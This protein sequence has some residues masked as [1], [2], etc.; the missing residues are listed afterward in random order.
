MNIALIYP[1]AATAH[2]KLDK[3]SAKGMPIGIA[4]LGAYLEKEGH[5][6]NLVDAEA[7]D[8]SIE[9]TIKEALKNNPK[10]VGISC[11][12]VSIME[13]YKLVKKI[14]EENPEIKT[15]IGGSHASSTPKK[16]LSSS[17]YLDFVIYGEGEI[18]L[19]E[20][21][22][23]IEE[24][25]SFED[26]NGL[27]YKKNNEIIINKPRKLIENLDSIPF[28]ARHLLPLNKYIHSI[29]WE[30]TTIMITS[31][32]CPN[33]CIFCGSKM[34][35]GRRAR[36]RSVKNVIKEID[37][38]VNK[39]KIKNI[40]MNDD[41]FTLNKQRTIKICKEIIKNNFD[42]KFLCAS[43]VNTMDQEV[44]DYLEK[45]G[46]KIVTF[47]IESGDEQILKNIKKGIDL[48]QVKKAVE[49]VKNT[50]MEAHGSFMFGNPGETEETMKKTIEFAKS[51]PLDK[52]QF[53]ITTPFPGTELWDIAKKEGGIKTEDFSQ[54]YFYNC[55]S[56][57]PT[58]LT[59]KKIKEYQKKAYNEC[60][61]STKSGIK[62]R[63]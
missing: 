21:V 36:F 29:F 31:R 61:D 13:A 53:S 28:P 42:I 62:M 52:Y 17:E 57:V 56:Y 48:N 26:I 1:Y 34:T 20:L 18:T 15:M 9:D 27:V 10:L 58:G 22:K 25:K 6:M 24:N 19:L 23:A 43:R 39:F 59:E 4:Y 45:A 37:E 44:A 55:V 32:G 54:F 46:C 2:S 60:F 41:T 51:L 33:N 5:N 16:T 38:I 47:G 7:L 35:F 63:N 14:K 49:A 8:L 11:E 30:K 12:T 3:K 50:S 40:V